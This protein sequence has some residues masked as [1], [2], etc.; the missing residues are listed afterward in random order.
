MA[1][2]PTASIPSLCGGGWAETK[3]AY[4][5]L[6]NPKLDFREVLRAHSE[7]VLARI[8][9]RERVL[10]L[11]DTTELDFSG[12]PSMAGLGRLNYDQRQG[13]Y[14][15]PTLVIDEAGVALGVIDCWHWARR[16]KGEP[17]LAESLRWV[18]GYERVAEMAA[19]AGE[20]RL[21]YVADREGDLRALI[22]RAVALHHAAD[23]LIRVQ[24]D[25]KLGTR[26][27]TNCGRRSKPNRDWARFASTCRP[28]TS[29]R[30]GWWN[31]RSGPP[32]SN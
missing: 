22:D 8:R 11:Q 19:L 16:P 7:P 6:D 3:A 23:Y 14:L 31:R 17:D 1:G 12:R 2:D 18:E 29:T 26:C 25:R 20:A 4:R 9:A 27:T 10:C 30:P 21:V 28:A 32:G 5:L 24:H 15:H 13:L